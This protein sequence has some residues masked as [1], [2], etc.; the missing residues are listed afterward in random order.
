MYPTNKVNHKGMSLHKSLFAKHIPVVRDELSCSGRKEWGSS[1]SLQK[2][3][4]ML[5]PSGRG[6]D[7]C[8]GTSF[9]CGSLLDT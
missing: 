4:G 7:R 8:L 3:G 9:A 5:Q 1:S 6:G 2:K